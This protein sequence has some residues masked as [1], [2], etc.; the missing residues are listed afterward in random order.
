MKFLALIGLGMV[1]TTSAF[2]QSAPARQ[3]SQA[4]HPR[5]H[6]YAADFYE[7]NHEGQTIIHP[8]R[9]LGSSRH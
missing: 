3:A 7:P 4:T 2:A 8:D 5:V 9:Q 1:L 6:V